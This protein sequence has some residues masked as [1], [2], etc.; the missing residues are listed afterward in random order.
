M[1]DN[2]FTANVLERIKAG[3]DS[4]AKQ[5]VERDDLILTML[6]T[7]PEE[8]QEL[9]QQKATELRNKLISI[10]EEKKNKYTDSLISSRA[11]QFIPNTNSLCVLLVLIALDKN[12]KFE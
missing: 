3:V 4:E 12:I 10:A 6:K 7:F 2:I 1:D 8:V 5:K 11:R 9:I